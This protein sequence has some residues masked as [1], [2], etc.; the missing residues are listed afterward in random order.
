MALFPLAPSLSLGQR[1]RLP[2]PLVLDFVLL[3]P[4]AGSAYC[5]LTPQAQTKVP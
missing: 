5:R 1:D 3:K 2:P 4:G